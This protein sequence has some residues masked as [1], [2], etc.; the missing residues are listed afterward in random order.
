MKLLI[1]PC[2]LVSLSLAAAENQLTV[3]QMDQVTRSI[4]I[5]YPQGGDLPC[6]VHYRKDGADQLLWQA[7]NDSGYCEQQAA[8]FIEKQRSWGWQCTTDSQPET[9]G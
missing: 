4:E 3:C 2:C 9:G 5:M 8:A 6:E 7:E 1:L